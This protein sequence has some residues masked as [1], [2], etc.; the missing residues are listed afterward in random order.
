MKKHHMQLYLYYNTDEC[1]LRLEFRDVVCWCFVCAGKGL[2]MDLSSLQGPFVAANAT[3]ALT[4]PTVAD[5]SGFA[6]QY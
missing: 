3:L 2:F 6:G 1:L 5:K 4:G